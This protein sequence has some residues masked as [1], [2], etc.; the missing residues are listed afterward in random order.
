MLTVP[1]LCISVPVK[2]A[3]RWCPMGRDEPKKEE[4][5]IRETFAKMFSKNITQFVVERTEYRNKPFRLKIMTEYE[6][7]E[8]V[9]H[10]ML[11]TGDEL[12]DIT[13]SILEALKKVKK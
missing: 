5:V 4:T 7:K 6:G 3:M 1:C 13:N 12:L 11:I 10:T 8:I 2:R 9:L